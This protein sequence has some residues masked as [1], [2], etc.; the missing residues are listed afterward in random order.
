VTDTGV[1]MREDIRARLFEPF[2]STQPFGANRGMGLASVHGMVHQSR[3]F[4]E[5]DSAPGEGTAIRLYFPLAGTPPLGVPAQPEAPVDVR[6]GGVLL[7][8]DDHM[9]RDLCRRMLEKLGEVVYAVASGA[10]ALDFLAARA[11]DVSLLITDLTMPG[12]SGLELID[13][14]AERYPALPMAA[15]SGYVVN[16]DARG[17]LD[18]RGAAFLPK[19]FAVHDLARLLSTA[20]R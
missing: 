14:A 9:L 3:G 11:S 1:G 12:M 15:I 17:R 18:T 8:D 7:V 16:P 19:P 5:C 13:A 20:R 10:E 6:S 2:F 4:L